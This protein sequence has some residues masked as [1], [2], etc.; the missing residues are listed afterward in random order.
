M[1]MY[2]M[3]PLN[4][5]LRGLSDFEKIF[6][7]RTSFESI[8]CDIEDLGKSYCLTADMPGFDKN[9]INI[10]VNDN[11]MTISASR[12]SESEDGAAGYL[13]R[14]RSFGKITRSFNVSNVRKGEIRASYKDGVLR[15]IMPKKDQ[16]GNTSEHILIE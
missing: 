11:I 13:R 6:F 9:D 7:P 3:S 2:E 16:T 8:S 12:K 10:D 1:S 14:E 4:G 15:L 5:A